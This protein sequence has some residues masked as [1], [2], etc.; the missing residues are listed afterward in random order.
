MSSL[1]SDKWG[2][3]KIAWVQSSDLQSAIDGVKE[4]KVDGLGISSHHGFSGKDISFLNAVTD[5]LRGL[6]FPR[7]DNFNIALIEKFRKLRFLVLTDPKQS[8]D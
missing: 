3:W 4:G 5:D 1:K 7:A 6:V 8:L 2:K